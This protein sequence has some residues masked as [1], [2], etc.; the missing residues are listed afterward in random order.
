MFKEFMNFHYIIY[1]APPPPYTRTPDPGAIKFTILVE[2]LLLIIT[3]HLV[4]LSIT[5]KQRRNFSKTH[6]FLLYNLWS[7]TLTP[8]PWTLGP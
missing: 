7:P 6:V 4:S 8:E 3:M 2:A 1:R 5:Y